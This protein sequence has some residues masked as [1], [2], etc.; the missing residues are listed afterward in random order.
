M[1]M[2]VQ[3]LIDLLRDGEMLGYSFAASRRDVGIVNVD[4]RAVR[5]EGKFN[6]ANVVAKINERIPDDQ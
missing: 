6:L 1:K 5:I 3:D 2:T 4:D